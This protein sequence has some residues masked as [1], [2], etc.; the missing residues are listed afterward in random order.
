M[1][2]KLLE[3]KLLNHQKIIIEKL[4]IFENKKKIE[5]DEIIIENQIGIFGNPKGTGKTLSIIGLILYKNKNNNNIKKI[6][7]NRNDY[8][9]IKKQYKITNVTVIICSNYMIEYWISELKLTELRYNKYNNKKTIIIDK[10]DVI[11]CTPKTFIKLINKNQNI[12]WNRIIYE[13]PIINTIKYI[14]NIY[15]DFLWI[16][17]NNPYELLNYSDNTLLKN[18]LNNIS[19]FEYFEKLIIKNEDKELENLYNDE[20]IKFRYNFTNND[21]VN[22]ILN[23]NNEIIINKFNNINEYIN[24][25]NL[26]KMDEPKTCIICLQNIIKLCLLSCCH[27]NYCY[28]CIIKWLYKKESCPICRIIIYLKNINLI[29]DQENK[30][31]V[32]YKNDFIINFLNKIDKYLIVIDCLNKEIIKNL[33][34]IN[35]IKIIKNN[36]IKYEK[37]NIYILNCNK[38]MKGLNLQFIDNIIFYEKICPI[39]HEQIINF[40]NRIGKKKTLK[41]FYF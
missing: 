5:S 8:I 2:F 39:K 7:I 20:I 18:L 10:Y 28:D 22:K 4:N 6:T 13:E 40:I 16:I 15:F 38:I 1:D 14:N 11:L 34:N 17:S 33:Q 27:S 29:N 12:C 26:N 3:K 19:L 25:Y 32:K 9:E 36:L 37:Y 31:I 24:H 21:I 23:N 41:I 35:K 30:E